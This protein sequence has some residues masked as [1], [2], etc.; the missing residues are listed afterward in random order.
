MEK[1]RSNLNK[2]LFSSGG[3]ERGPYEPLLEDDEDRAPE[4][5]INLLIHKIVVLSLLV[6]AKSKYNS[7][8][9]FL[10]DA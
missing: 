5:R 9:S 6:N 2:A 3:Y 8:I 7:F 10:K 1:V 4:V